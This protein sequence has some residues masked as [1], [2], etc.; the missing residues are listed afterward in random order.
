MT[1]SE[2]DLFMKQIRDNKAKLYVTLPNMLPTIT[3]A[4]LVQLAEDLDVKIFH[5]LWIKDPTTGKHMLTNEA[6]MV[7]KLPIR[8]QQQFLDKK[9]SV[10]DSDRKIDQLTGQVTSDDKSSALS[11]PEIQILYSRGL[12]T[13]LMELIKVRGGDINAYG[14]FKR[15][16][17]ETGEGE[18]NMIDLNSRTRSAVIAGVYMT[19]MHIGNNI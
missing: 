3:T 9:M 15:Q 1:D 2:F 5:K 18:L 7:L 17:E 6:H 16:M 8:R 11:N 10:P 19:G 12:E 13:T 14:E 4:E